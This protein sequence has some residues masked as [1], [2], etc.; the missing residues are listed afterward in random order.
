VNHAESLKNNAIRLAYLEVGGRYWNLK[1][2]KRTSLDQQKLPIFVLISGGIITFLLLGMTWILSESEKR[3]RSLAKK[4]TAEFKYSEER[5]GRLVELSPEGI[6]IQSQGKLIYINPA[7]SQILG[8]ENQRD[9]IGRNIQD[10][11]CIESAEKA[12]KI[13]MTIQT[14]ERN[15]G[16]VELKIIKLNREIIDIEATGLPIIYAG[17]PAAQLIF[18]DISD[19][20]KAEIALK[21]NE[22][23]LRILVT[24][25]PVGIF[26][27]DA[28]G[29]CVF[30]NDRTLEIMNRPSTDIIGKHW[31]TYIHPEDCHKVIMEIENSAHNRYIFAMEY[32]FIT[33]TNQIVWVFGNAIPIWG[34]NEEIISYFG[35]ITDITERKR[36]EQRLEA[37]HRITRILSEVNNIRQANRQIIK[38]ICESLGWDMGG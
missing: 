27:A 10:F 2:I 8:A 7:G 13:L 11:I 26:Q 21:D 5:Y 28:Q 6:A 24:N 17:E 22:E 35:T 4:M 36:T 1:F 18:R 30:V 38:A 9:L 33:P 16:M 23:R 32:R 14:E 19:R 25:V 12:E 31:I 15:K 34:E 3:A 37:Q 29:E 20:K